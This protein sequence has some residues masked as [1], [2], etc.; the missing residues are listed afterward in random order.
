M[1]QGCK[2]F[3][4]TEG[5]CSHNALFMKPGSELIVVRKIDS[6][7]GYQ[8]PINSMKELNVT[9][10][11]ASL[12]HFPSDRK[13][14]WAGPFFIYL[15]KRLAAFAGVRPHFPVKTYCQYAWPQVK[16]KTKRLIKH[17]L[18]MDK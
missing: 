14:P 6:C 18:R 4:T 5:S 12:T 3:A 13:K 8:H 16:R 2:S 1:L 7:N 10:I 17:V 11:D 9:Y 15:N